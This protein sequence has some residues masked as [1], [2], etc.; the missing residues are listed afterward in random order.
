MT[1]LAQA[2]IDSCQSR[3][4]ESADVPK[5]AATT[6]PA[7]APRMRPAFI[8]CATEVSPCLAEM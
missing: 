7:W 4:S 5:V 2:S 3:E 6:G 1:G 8:A